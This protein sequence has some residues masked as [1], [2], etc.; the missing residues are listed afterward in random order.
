MSERVIEIVSSEYNDE[1]RDFEDLIKNTYR[2]YKLRNYGAKIKFNI[3]KANAG[4]KI[5]IMCGATEIKTYDNITIEI[6]DE[7]I[8]NISELFVEKECKSK[9]MNDKTEKEKEKEEEKE[10]KKG[11]EKYKRSY[12]KNKSKYFNLLAKIDESNI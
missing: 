9:C 1:I 7:I 8:K 11:K 12:E 2:K 3:G 4:K 6:L 10:K 5:T